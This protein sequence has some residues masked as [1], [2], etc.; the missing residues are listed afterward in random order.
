MSCVYRVYPVL[1]P[2]TFSV[3]TGPALAS[4]EDYIYRGTAYNAG[5]NAALR[6]F[7]FTIAQVSLI[8]TF[9]VCYIYAPSGQCIASVRVEGEDP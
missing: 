9:D 5:I 4:D 7:G 2:S 1:N 3:D 8:W 6:F